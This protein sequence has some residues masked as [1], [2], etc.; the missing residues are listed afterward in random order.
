MRDPNP[1]LNGEYGEREARLRL[2]GGDRGLHHRD[3]LCVV[4][5]EP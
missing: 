4:N 5:D 3:E 1:D 2:V